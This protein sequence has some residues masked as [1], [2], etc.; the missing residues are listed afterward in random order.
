MTICTSGDKYCSY[1][2]F[3]A[4]NYFCEHGT[5]KHIFKEKEIEV[6]YC[7]LTEDNVFGWCEQVDD[8]SWL[9][10]IHNA[11]GY[12]EHFRTLFHEYMHVVQDIEGLKDEGLREHQAYQIEGIMYKEMC[13]SLQTVH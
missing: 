12:E 13:G 8:N 11:L 3:D 5:H 7:D 4:Y 1:I 10:H 6:H 2:A 9:I